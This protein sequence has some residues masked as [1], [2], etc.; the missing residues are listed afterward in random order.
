[1]GGVRSK[2][3][4]SLI[5]L[6]ARIAV[7]AVVV[8]AVVVSQLL[9]VTTT[10]MRLVVMVGGSEGNCRLMLIPRPENARGSPGGAAHFADGL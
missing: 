5:D 2:E 3:V 4:I 8:V 10:R 9:N 6:A 1:M 7:M